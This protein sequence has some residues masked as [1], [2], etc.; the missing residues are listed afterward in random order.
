MEWCCCVGRELPGSGDS[1]QGALQGQGSVS[2]CQHRDD[3]PGHL[4]QPEPVWRAARAQHRCRSCCSGTRPPCCGSL[5]WRVGR[6][7]SREQPLHEEPLGRK[8]FQLRAAPAQRCC[9][10]ML[11][12]RS[13]LC[14]AQ[15]LPVAAAT[16]VLQPVG[17][18]GFL[19]ERILVRVAVLLYSRKSNQ[20]LAIPYSSKSSLLQHAL[21]KT[22]RK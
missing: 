7:G 9:S 1:L 6:A 22:R 4:S 14:A 2:L 11:G 5:G 21:R 12:I 17:T 18:C 16:L 15:N 3:H 13:P 20:L 10:A 19:G 8:E